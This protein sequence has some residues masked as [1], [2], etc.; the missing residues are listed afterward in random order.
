PY[1][2]RDGSITPGQH[3]SFL[4]KKHDPFLVTDDPNAADFQLSEL[5]LPEN[6]SLGRLE[7]RRQLRE[8]I[9]RQ[10]RL[11][12]YSAE[13][14]GLDD[15]YSTAMSMLPTSRIRQAFDLASEPAKLR[16]Q[17][18]RTTYGQSLLL[19]R[20]LVEAGVRFVNVYF[21]DRIGGRSTESGGWDTHGFDGSRMY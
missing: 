18:G 12:D 3:A 5:S 7:N 15:Y 20:R 17:Y 9:E 6:L 1:T 4:G 19:A 16:E 11:L 14:R 2:I 10:T 21:S 8:L 13:A